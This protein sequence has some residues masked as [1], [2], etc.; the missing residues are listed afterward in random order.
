MQN[1]LILS[2]PIYINDLDFSPPTFLLDFDVNVLLNGSDEVGCLT[3]VPSVIF[4]TEAFEVNK[5]RTYN[6][7]I[8]QLRNGF[9]Q[10]IILQ[11]FSNI[12]FKTYLTKILSIFTLSQ[13]IV[14]SGTPVALQ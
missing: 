11:T 5:I 7:F 10:L 2:L 8:S 1:T 9:N 13:E 12:L 14:G 3:D 4:R 6:Y